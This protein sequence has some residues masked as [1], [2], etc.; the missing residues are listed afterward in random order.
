MDQM[1]ASNQLLRSYAAQ[2]LEAVCLETARWAIW[3]D[4]GSIVLCLYGLFLRF[5]NS[6]VSRKSLRLNGPD[7]RFKPVCWVVYC[8]SFA[9]RQ[10]ATRLPDWQ[11]EV[12]LGPLY[13]VFRDFF[14]GFSTRSCQESP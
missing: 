1:G 3:G 8:S 10:C 11:F 2:V 12:T 14:R 4:F 13:F 7:R 6:I 5:L 9:G